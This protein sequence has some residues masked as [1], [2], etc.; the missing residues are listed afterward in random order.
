MPRDRKIGVALD[1]SNSS[2]SALNWTI[3]NL[4][5]K[6]DTLYVIHVKY[7]KGDEARHVLW[8]NTGSPTALIPLSELLD[9]ELMKKYDIQMAPD[10]LDL[11]ET[12]YTKEATVVGKLYLGDARDK[13]CSAVEDLKLD[14]LVMGS[15]GLS[16]IR[17]ILLGSVT[18]HVITHASCPITIV[19]EPKSE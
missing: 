9:P 7:D 19:K 17:R 8:A 11:L 12:A 13:L 5:D 4:L 14:S 10:V 18:N 6:G 16:T 15:R 2:R 1:F 3:E